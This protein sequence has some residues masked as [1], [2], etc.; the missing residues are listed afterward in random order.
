MEQTVDTLL[1]DMKKAVIYL[2]ALFL[3]FGIITFSLPL[4]LGKSEVV[5]MVSGAL[6][7]VG[8]L[9][10]IYKIRKKFWTK[11]VITFTQ[12]SIKIITIL[13]SR[14]IFWGEMETFSFG[15]DFYHFLANFYVISIY[16][17]QGNTVNLAII[18]NHL[19]NNLGE[20]NSDSVL[21]HF[22]KAVVFYNANLDGEAQK[23]GIKKV[24]S[25]VK[26]YSPN[27]PT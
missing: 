11:A 7:F 3:I 23:I 10:V 12:E 4:F 2:L 17:W 5:F 1:Y 26:F 27:T 16:R 24:F 14:E 9:G 8:P 18:D 22:Y 13:K 25:R 15:R 19:Q 6:F 21:F 20:F